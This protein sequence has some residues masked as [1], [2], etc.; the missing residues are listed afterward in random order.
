[1]LESAFL[2]W[3]LPFI[4]LSPWSQRSSRRVL[5]IHIIISFSFMLIY[6]YVRTTYGSNLR[7]LPKQVRSTS[8]REFTANGCKMLVFEPITTK[9]R[10]ILLF[11]GLGI[12][13]RRMLQESCMDAFIEDSEIVCFQVRGLG[14]SDWNVDF[15]SKSM[16]EDAL[17]AVSVF[18]LMTDCKLQTLFIGYSLGC[19]VSMQLLSHNCI[20]GVKCDNI[21]LVNGMCS[22]KKMVS[23]FK[24][25]ASLLNLDVKRH[26]KNCNVPI[27]VLHAQDDKTIPIDEAIELKSECDSIGRHCKIL[28]CDGDHNDYEL[29]DRTKAFL[30][31]L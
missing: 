1:M 28:T 18:D 13:V 17:N 4:Y 23:H 24:L 21:L 14:E 3:T 15:S 25:F 6:I 20:T 19:F 29:S 7:D 16:L 8:M 11:P 22:G 31:K 9:K 12:S 26:V 2:C 10:R 27:T 5:K 30:R